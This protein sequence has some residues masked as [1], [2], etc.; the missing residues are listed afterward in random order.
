VCPD[1]ALAATPILDVL[2]PEA[3]RWDFMQTI[4][5]RGELFDKSTVRWIGG[6]NIGVV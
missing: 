1:N 2:A 4:P 5:N 3:A 6:H